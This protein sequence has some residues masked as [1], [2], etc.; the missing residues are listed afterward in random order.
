MDSVDHISEI[1]AKQ[2]AAKL[3]DLGAVLIVVR[4]M[5][6]A[7]N[8]SSSVL[9]VPA[10]INQDMKTSPLPESP[11]LLEQAFVSELENP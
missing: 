4:G 7:K 10:V 5:V 3:L 8:V 2:S 6:L 11:A 9:S 1:A